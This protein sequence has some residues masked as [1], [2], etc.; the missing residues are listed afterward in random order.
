MRT[1]AGTVVTAAV[2]FGLAVQ[3]I[4]SIFFI[5]LGALGLGAGGGV[6]GTLRALRFRVSDSAAP[7]SVA[8]LG[9]V[10]I[11]AGTTIG[12]LGVARSLTMPA[13]RLSVLPSPVPARSSTAVP[14]PSVVIP[15]P[16]VSSSQ[17]PTAQPSPTTSPTESAVYLTDLPPAGSSGF[18]QG[19]WTI[20]SR[21]Y[22][23]CLGTMAGFSVSAEYRLDSQYRR[24]QAVFVTELTPAGELPGLTLSLDD[25]PAIVRTT[26]AGHPTSIDIDVG[27]VNQMK[28]A[29]QGVG[30]GGVLVILCETRLT[31]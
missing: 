26:D 25:K 29:V 11:A 30:F 2:L 18:V 23:H 15:S 17:T 4:P 24:F 3:F 12:G 7:P 28:V 20:D 22:H 16:V 10:L 13:P 31:P 1:V 9:V 19:S 27:G 5:V 21:A 14:T 6:L 8:A